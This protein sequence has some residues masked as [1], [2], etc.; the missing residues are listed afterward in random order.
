MKKIDML[1]INNEEIVEGDLVE[2]IYLSDEEKQEL[3]ETG[4]IEK[5][6]V[7]LEFKKHLGLETYLARVID[8]KNSV[9]VSVELLY[10]DKNGKLVGTYQ[11]HIDY[12]LKHNKTVN[13]SELTIEALEKSENNLSTIKKDILSS[14]IDRYRFLHNFVY[15]SKKIVKKG[16][17]G[18]ERAALLNDLDKD[19]TH[20]KLVNGLEANVEDS[21]LIELSAESKNF[22]KERLILM[23]EEEDCLGDFTHLKTTLN[24]FDKYTYKLDFWGTDSQGDITFFETNLN[25]DLYNEKMRDFKTK[26]RAKFD[27]KVE[28]GEDP[29]EMNK[30]KIKEYHIEKKRL[31]RD[32][33]VLEKEES[34]IFISMT[35]STDVLN[36]LIN[37]GSKIEVI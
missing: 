8:S 13:E 24:K 12:L 22:V 11:D 31:M 29:E 19:G 6:K 35:S 14:T 37:Q 27:K 4:T 10:A 2:L 20:F 7:N 26:N 17:V 5:T 32:I 33:S 16:I 34:S 21:F 25:R 23:I 18:A 36:V 30:Q 3:S 15:V 9:G 1:D 28:L